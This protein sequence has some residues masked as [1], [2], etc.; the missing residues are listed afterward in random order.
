MKKTET[1]NPVWY[2]SMCVSQSCFSN[3]SGAESDYLV[4]SLSV[5]ENYCLSASFTQPIK[6]ECQWVS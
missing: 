5:F 1:M 6:R 4:C 3:Q 2:V